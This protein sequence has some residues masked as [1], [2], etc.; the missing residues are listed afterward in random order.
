[1]KR[2][3]LVFAVSALFLCCTSLHAGTIL[4]SENFNSATANL[5]VT[6]AGAFHTTGGTNVDIVSAPSGWASLI[7]APESGNVVDMGGSGGNP[8]GILTSNS[9]F[10]LLPGVDYYLSFDLVGSQRGYDTSTTVTF[11]GYD[12]TF[13]LASGDDTDGLVTN[14]LVT[15]STPT[16][17]NLTF[18]NN[19]PQDGNVGALLDNIEIASTATPEPSSLL[20]LGSGFATIALFFARGRKKGTPTA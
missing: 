10:E 12:Q 18:T 1:M 14:A 3:S 11:G 2:T 8:Q 5:D 4:L 19:S 17:T 20:L 16:W 9:S 15:V 13:N 7:V 6:S